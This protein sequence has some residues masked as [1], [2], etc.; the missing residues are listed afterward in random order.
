MRKAL[1]LSG[2]NRVVR[3]PA[4]PGVADLD[5]ALRA[6]IGRQIAALDARLCADEPGL[7]PGKALRDLGGLKRLLDELGGTA[8]NRKRD[9][10]A[11]GEPQEGFDEA[12]DAD[13]A[14]LRDRIARQVAAFAGDWPP[15]RVP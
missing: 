9:G 14:D 1:G 13:L 7:D 3:A 6:H 8:R 15:E 2:T 10:E 11:D 4:A 5:A 12:P